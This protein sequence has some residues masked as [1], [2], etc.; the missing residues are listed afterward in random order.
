MSANSARHT[1]MHLPPL[2]NLSGKLCV[3]FMLACSAPAWAGLAGFEQTD[4]YTVSS[5]GLISSLQSLVDAGEKTIG[6]FLPTAEYYYQDIVTLAPDIRFG[7]DLSRYNAG[8]YSGLGGATDI[9]DNS[10]LWT[11]VYGGRLVEDDMGGPWDGWGTDYAAANTVKAHSGLQSLALR[12][13]D[14]T[15]IY[16]YRLD[17]KDLASSTGRLQFS[18]WATP[19][20]A[21]Q[22]YA[23]NVFG[24]SLKNS[25]GQSMFE[26]GYSGDDFLQY[27][28]NGTSAW[29]TTGTRL[30]DLGWS[31]I[32]MILDTN[33]DTVSLFASSYDDASGLLGSEQMMVG[34]L[35]LGANATDLSSL[36]WTL[37]GGTLDP[38][39]INEA[40]YI[41]DLSLSV[42]PEPTSGLFVLSAAM[43]AGCRR[44][45]DWG[46]RDA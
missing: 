10:G 24:M 12:A 32:S 25:A 43:L 16:G 15:I 5:S 1:I 8:Q 20:I 29:T 41:D 44:R 3:A 27:R 22:S 9:A 13:T 34:D 18:F 2:Y 36:D 30:G 26:V 28:L 45:R 21:D 39:S 7:P 31:Q 35:A 46:W 14:D 42:V 40:H 4:G 38:T 19:S 33:S 37:Q 11:A 23:G 17:S 6:G